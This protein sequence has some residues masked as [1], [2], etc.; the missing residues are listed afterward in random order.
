MNIKYLFLCLI[1]TSCQTYRT[2][3]D[4]P[5]GIGVPCESVSEIQKRIIETPDG[6]EDIF[7]NGNPSCGYYY[8]KLY[9]E[10][11]RYIQKTIETKRIWIK[12]EASGCGRYIYFGREIIPSC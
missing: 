2:H 4:C 6:Q 9:P 7:L 8:P 12:D 3:F 11:P 5:P 10:T 1:L